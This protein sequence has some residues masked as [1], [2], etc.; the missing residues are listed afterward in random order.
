MDRF[1]HKISR[2]AEGCKVKVANI[3][4][5]ETPI[6]IFTRLQ[7]SIRLTEAHSVDIPTRFIVLLIGNETFTNELHEVG[8]CFGTLM[9]DDVFR[10]VAYKSKTKE[11]LLV[12]LSE[13]FDKAWLL[14]PN[15]WDPSIMLDPPALKVS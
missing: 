6:C 5:I 15:E 1:E 7:S 3:S 4:C 14:P 13:M 10:G 2:H 11:E 8:R 9:S 12:G